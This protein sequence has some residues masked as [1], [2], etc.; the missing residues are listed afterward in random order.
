[1]KSGR[2]LTDLALELNRQ[3]A[4]KRDLVLAGALLRTLAACPCSCIFSPSTTGWGNLAPVT[5]LNWRPQE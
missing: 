1:M 3:L 4:T 5:G 2:S